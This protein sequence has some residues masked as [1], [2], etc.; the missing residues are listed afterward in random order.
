MGHVSKSEMRQ[1]RGYPIGG[2]DRHQAADLQ[3]SRDRNRRE[4]AQARCRERCRDGSDAL[5]AVLPFVQR[6][7]DD[8]EAAIKPAL[9]AGDACNDDPAYLA[10]KRATEAYFLLA[11][12]VGLDVAGSP[13]A[14]QFP[15]YTEREAN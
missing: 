2:G 14:M 9:D 8:M 4:T 13:L 6:L 10:H 12:A 3:Q 11:D 15:R 7:R 1:H 5:D